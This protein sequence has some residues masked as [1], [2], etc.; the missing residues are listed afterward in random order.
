M[1]FLCMGRDPDKRGPDKRGLTVFVDVD[2]AVKAL[3]CAYVCVCVWGGG[4]GGG[5]V[6]ARTCVCVCVLCNIL[7]RDVV[8]LLAFRRWH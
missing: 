2:C 6:R 5:G 4:G 7:R 8:A 1:I 3:P